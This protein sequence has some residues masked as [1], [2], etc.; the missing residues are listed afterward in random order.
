MPSKSYNPKA[1]CGDDCYYFNIGDEKKYG[2]CWGDVEVVGEE[3]YDYGD[4]NIDWNWVH[5]CQA[6]KDM[7]DNQWESD[8]VKY[9]IKEPENDK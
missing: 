2:E 9:Y 7:Y 1:C 8:S 5:S 4:D 6:H 3:C